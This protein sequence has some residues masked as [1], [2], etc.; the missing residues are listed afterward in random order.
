[1]KPLILRSAPISSAL[2]KRQHSTLLIVDVQQKLVPTIAAS[3]TITRS[4]TFLQRV[5][6]VLNVPVVISEQ[7][8]QGLGNTIGDIRSESPDAVVFEKVRFSAA[9]E[10][11]EHVALDRHQVVIVGIETHVCVLQTAF[12]L[13]A[14]GYQVGVVDDAVSSRHAADH[15]GAL[16]RL[17]Q[18]G[19]SVPVSESVAFEWCEQAGTDQFRQL[20]RLVRA[21]S[22]ARW[23]S[24]H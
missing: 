3:A 12:E 11:Q 7:Y 18:Q 9:Q 20:S 21:F 2:F 13:Q 1:M 17:R 5:A 6:A 24:D 23:Q 10:F 14:A 19:I 15:S 16:Q 22:D 4:I 8:P